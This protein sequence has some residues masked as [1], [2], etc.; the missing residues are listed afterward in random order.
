MKTLKEI[1][2]MD[3]MKCYQMGKPVYC[4]DRHISLNHL[5]DI[6]LS[7]LT[8][9]DVRYL[10]TEEVTYLNHDSILKNL[11]EKLE[12]LEDNRITNEEKIFDIFAFSNDGKVTMLTV[13]KGWVVRVGDLNRNFVLE[14]HIIPLKQDDVISVTSLETSSKFPAC[15][16]QTTLTT[17]SSWTKLSATSS[18]DFKGYRILD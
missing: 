10:V 8:C 3:A 16:G 11:F 14:E 6:C 12:R 7:T 15:K 13:G 9:N 5:K 2:V 4:Y 18:Y 17:D 1:S